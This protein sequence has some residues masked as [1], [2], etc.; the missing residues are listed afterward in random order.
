M[1]ERG[2]GIVVECV[3]GFMAPDIIESHGMVFGAI[4]PLWSGGWRL[5][6]VPR[7]FQRYVLDHVGEL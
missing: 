4:V 5:D 7:L 6:V 2:E 3:G 1:G